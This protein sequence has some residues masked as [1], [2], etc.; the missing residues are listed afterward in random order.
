VP[1]DWYRVQATDFSGSGFDRGHMTPN[2]D[3]DKETSIPINQATFLMSNMVAQSPDNNQ[4]PW[5]A[6]ENYLRTLLPAN[7]VY[8]VSGPY[9]VGG[10]GS[11]GGTT[12]T[13]AAGH[14][15]VPASTWK[16]ALVIPKASG[17][18]IS[19]VM[20]NSTTVAVSMPNMQGIR[21][22]PWQN[23]LTTVDL[24][25]NQTTYNFFSNLPAGIQN[26]IESGVNGTGNHPG[27]EGQSVTTNEETAVAITLT[28]ESAN[29]N[30]LT[31]TIVSGPSHGGLSG[32]GANRTY[33]PDLNYFGSDSFTFKV[34]D[35]VNDSNTSTVTI[36]V[37]NVEDAPDAVDDTP[38]IAEDS[39]ANVINVLGNDTDVDNDTLTVTA[40]TQ[41]SHGSV[42][43]N[44]PSVSYTPNSNFFG[45]D[46]FTY[47]IS[48]GNGGTDTA[49][50]NVTVTNVEDAPDAVDD[51]PTIAE[52]SGANVINVLGNDT[53]VDN[54]TLTVTAVTQGSHGSVANNG[55]SVS[56]TPNSNFFGT[57]TFTYTISDGHGGTDTA[58]VNVTITNVNDAPVAT[59]DNYVTNSNT[60]LNVAAPGVLS[61]DNDIDG[62]SLSAVYVA[63]SGPSHGTLSLSG[64]GSFSY[65]PSANY[66]GPDSFSYRA[67]DGSDYSNVAT[68]TITVNDT[69][70]PTLNSTLAINLL[71]S[72]NSDLINVGLNATATDNSGTPVQIQVAVFGDEDDET[73]TKQNILHSPDAK[74]IGP[75]NTLRLRAERVEANDGRVYL[76]IVTATDTS[77]NVSRSY[78]T[79]VVPKSNKQ[80][81][82]DSVNAQAAAAVSYAQTHNGAP[83]PGYFV[84]GDGPII[85]PKQ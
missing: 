48:D 75:D 66:S 36:T 15:T 20:C 19:R 7:E 72:T 28:A 35:G 13:L 16:V 22:D 79:V 38:T 30:P 61:N 9:G 64:N 12:T 57:D 10:T 14:V 50:V 74:D 5:A 8:I 53:D 80:A 41:G 56:Y 84:I 71:T 77:G 43:N 67:F 17:D 76:I 42:T 68:V 70:A 46:T 24:I 3:R 34:N 51:A 33:T 65:A 47:T 6:F 29:A 82:I 85:G 32:T 21:N 26:C 63:A 4:G 11:N 81:N 1:P 40:V 58:T 73:P 23:Y 37:N 49:T 62:P 59:N 60:T 31:Y 78:H 52:D 83:P 27:T 2:A 18:D 44:G 45:T 39:G 25:E 54:D 55:T 69:V